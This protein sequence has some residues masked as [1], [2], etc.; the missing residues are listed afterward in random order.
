M[1]CMS[2]YIYNHFCHLKHEEA[3]YFLVF[4]KK[5]AVFFFCTLSFSLLN[6]E[7][8]RLLILKQVVIF[9]IVLLNMS[10]KV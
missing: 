5:L 9:F 2:I 3:F 7:S 8:F 4:L 1:T 6:Y 10:L